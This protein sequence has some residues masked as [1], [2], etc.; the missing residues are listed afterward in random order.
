VPSLLKMSRR[1]QELATWPKSRHL[2]QMVP[3]PKTSLRGIVI[4]GNAFP[5]QAMKVWLSKFGCQTELELCQ[6]RR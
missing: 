5:K 4:F 2:G 3:V 6:K 1:K